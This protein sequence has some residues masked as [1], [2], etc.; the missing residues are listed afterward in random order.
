MKRLFQ[1]TTVRRDTS[2][3]VTRKADEGEIVAP[4]LVDEMLVVAA[5]ADSAVA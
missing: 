3:R 1:S 4:S 5:V 2:P